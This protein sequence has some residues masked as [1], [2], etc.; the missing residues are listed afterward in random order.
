LFLFFLVLKITLKIYLSYYH[1]KF[2]FPSIVTC[3]NIINISKNF[4]A[5][6]I[7]QYDYFLKIYNNQKIS[8][9]K[10]DYKIS[11]VIF[12][13]P[14]DFTCIAVWKFLH[15]HLCTLFLSPIH[16]LDTIFLLDKTSYFIVRQTGCRED[17]DF[18]SSGDTVHCVYSRDSRLNHLLGIN[19]RPGVDGLS[20]RVKNK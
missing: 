1:H 8:K 17:W 10:K 18:L 12:I 13:T 20:C 4:V 3:K 14:A 7:A 2:I 16:F 11:N 19:P 9:F 5:Q 6:N 15:W